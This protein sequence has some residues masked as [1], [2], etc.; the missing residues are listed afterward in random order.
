[1]QFLKI[2]GTFNLSFL[3][4]I[5]TI[6]VAVAVAVVVIIIII[7]ITH[8]KITTKQL[9]TGQSCLISETMNTAVMS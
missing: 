2:Y 6:I 8:N 3:I 5:I 7:I 4:T 1:M 9:C